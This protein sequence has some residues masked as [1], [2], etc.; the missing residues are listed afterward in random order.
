MWKNGVL[1]AAPEQQQPVVVTAQYAEAERVLGKDAA[2]QMA[3]RQEQRKR[4]RS[5]REDGVGDTAPSHTPQSC[6]SIFCTTGCCSR[7]GVFL[8]IYVCVLL[9]LALGVRAAGASPGYSLLGLVGVAITPPMLF[10][11]F[12]ASTF[13]ESVDRTQVCLTFFTAILWMTPLM[14]LIY[15][16]LAPSGALRWLYVMDPVCG[17]CFDSVTECGARAHADC[18]LPDP[19]DSSRAFQWDMTPADGGRCQVPLE[20]DAEP[21]GLC[22]CVSR[23][24]VMAFFRAGFLEETLKYLSV[25][26]I[27]R[28][29][30][31]ADPSA[32]VLYAITAACG[33]ALAENLEYVLSSASASSEQALH[34]AIL[35]ALLSIPLHAGTGA[36]MGAMLARRRFVGRKVPDQ[37]LGFCHIIA[38]PV[39]LHGLYDYS[40]FA[41]PFGEAGTQVA[42]AVNNIVVPF[43]VVVATWLT[44]RAQYTQV[45]S[46][47]LVGRIPRV[48]VR[49][50]EREGILPHAK[51]SDCLC[52]NFLWDVLCCTDNSQHAI[53]LMRVTEIQYASVE[54]TARQKKQKQRQK[55]RQPSS[56]SQHVPLLPMTM[57][58]K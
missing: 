44:A 27:Y 28:K 57:P 43:A 22:T 33:F 58:V 54:A 9:G 51:L 17:D 26:S 18:C 2:A 21:S 6:G 5:L 50:L 55:Q 39:I 4:M 41:Q 46:H 8:A 19:H 7:L 52:R 32:L 12:L 13:G 11:F 14:F 53:G 42:A 37:N 36:V 35:R 1:L 45:D 31:V 49:L 29:D 40:A 3:K 15:G 24:M 48:N 30:Y 20:S 16:V 10:I 34:T 47:P 25:C 38:L 56:E 23:N